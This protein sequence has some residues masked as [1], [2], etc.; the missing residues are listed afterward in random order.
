MRAVKTF[1]RNKEKKL[2]QT[3]IILQSKKRF[4]NNNYYNKEYKNNVKKH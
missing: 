3:E 1:N 4:K 2:I